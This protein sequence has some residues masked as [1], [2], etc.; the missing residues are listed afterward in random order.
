[1]PQT[2]GTMTYL[3]TDMGQLMVIINYIRSQSYYSK[4]YLY[5]KDCDRGETW[6]IAPGH[7]GSK[8]TS[9]FD[10]LSQISSQILSQILS[11]TLSLILSQ[12]RPWFCTRLESDLRIFGPSDLWISGFPNLWTSEEK[13]SI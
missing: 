1:M 8:V 10:L 3:Q 6:I 2:N 12:I 9:T 5:F 7:P 11:W 4:I 13:T